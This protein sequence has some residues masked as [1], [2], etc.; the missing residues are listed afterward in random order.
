MNPIILPPA[1]GKIVEQTE[2]FILGQATSL[3][4]GKL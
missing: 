1:T 2:F 3:E 4:E